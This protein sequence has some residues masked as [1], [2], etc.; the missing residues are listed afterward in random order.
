MS[1]ACG[2]EG[3]DEGRGRR[4]APGE[5]SILRF[6]GGEDVSSLSFS[7]LLFLALPLVDEAKKEPQI[8]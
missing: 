6:D 5:L 4:S 2:P 3:G 1:S 8:K 7:G